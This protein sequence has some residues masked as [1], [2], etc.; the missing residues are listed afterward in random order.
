MGTGEIRAPMLQPGCR[1]VPGAMCRR[2]PAG[3][4]SGDLELGDLPT[5]APIAATREA[6]ACRVIDRV[7][8]PA[9]AA[10]ARAVFHRVTGPAHR[11]AVDTGPARPIAAVVVML[12]AARCRAI[13]RVPAMEVAAH[14]DRVRRIAVGVRTAVAAALLMLV[15]AAEVPSIVVVAEVVPS[16]A[17]AAEDLTLAAAGAAS[18]AL[19]SPG[20]GLIVVAAL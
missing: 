9:A 8:R 19:F 2:A 11:T 6:A 13:A 14:T 16:T 1:A 20:L 10:T 3:S 4:T 15:V 12:Q 5:P 17:E 18:A 7:L